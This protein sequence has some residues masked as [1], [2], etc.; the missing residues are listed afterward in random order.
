VDSAVRRLGR[1]HPFVKTQFFCEEIDAQAGMFPPG[2]QALMRG[3]HSARTEPEPGKTYAFLID[4]AGQ[5][6]A[7][8]GQAYEEER[9]GKAQSLSRKNPGRDSTSL[10]IVE[11]DRSTLA[12]LGKP[13]YLVI[14]R[15]EWTG[16]KLVQ[17][18]GALQALVQTWKPS[19]IVIDAT[20]VGELL[21]NAC[22][23]KVVLPVKFTAKLKSELGYGF[24]GM[25]E[26]GRYRE[27]APFP[28]S[29]RVQMD[30]CRSEIV[31]GPAMLMRWG[32]PD[33]T[34]D[35]A[36]RELV[37]DDDLVT[38]AL[39][40]MLDGLEWFTRLPTVWTTPR[41]PLREMDGSF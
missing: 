10:K 40:V 32:V 36:S 28:D 13:T 33:G 35:P 39:C 16:E 8:Q 22:G 29:L 9:L 4:V 7:N 2:R 41:D 18:F 37:H 27:Y 12:L 24:I 3:C 17:V 21:D 25:I 30:W 38:S 19:R 26:S 23:E 15:Q 20:G 11:I 6:E 1:Q 34:R 31:A 5:D 14:H